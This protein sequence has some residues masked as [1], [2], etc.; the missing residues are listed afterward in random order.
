MLLVTGKDA[1]LLKCD[2][3]VEARRMP[4]ETAKT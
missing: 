3:K 4:N 1:E 2:T